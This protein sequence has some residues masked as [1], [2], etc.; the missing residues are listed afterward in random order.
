VGVLDGWGSSPNNGG[1]MFL[2]G[3]GRSH[4]VLR[5]LLLFEEL[6]EHGGAVCIGLFVEN[7]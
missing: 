2:S 6:V 5:W 7:L 4:E 1:N 3:L